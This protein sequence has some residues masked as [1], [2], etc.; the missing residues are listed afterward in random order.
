MGDITVYIFI[1]ILHKYNDKKYFLLYYIYRA[2]EI[3]IQKIT[4]LQE[5]K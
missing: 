5:T 4:V 2:F 1:L 3:L